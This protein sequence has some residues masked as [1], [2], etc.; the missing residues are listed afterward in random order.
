[1]RGYDTRY[2]RNYKCKKYDIIFTSLYFKEEITSLER[3]LGGFVG[4]LSD[5]EYL[6]I[7]AITNGT[8]TNLTYVSNLKQMNYE[9]LTN[10]GM[11]IEYEFDNNDPGQY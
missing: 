10:D 6:Y 9:T 4:N 2:I 5:C 1:M 7:N 11:T 3:G 8:I